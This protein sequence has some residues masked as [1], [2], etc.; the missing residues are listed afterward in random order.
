MYSQT[1]ESFSNKTNPEEFNRIYSEI[2]D[3]TPTEK[4]WR[5]RDL[6]D[7]LP[8]IDFYAKSTQKDIIHVVIRDIKNL[9]DNHDRLYKVRA[10]YKWLFTPRG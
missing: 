2:T 5:I 1:A 8:S 10:R 3:A 9:P 7:R 6:V 4:G